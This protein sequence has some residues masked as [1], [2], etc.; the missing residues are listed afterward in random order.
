LFLDELQ[1]LQR[2]DNVI[3]YLHNALLGSLAGDA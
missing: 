1:H 2:L 3:N